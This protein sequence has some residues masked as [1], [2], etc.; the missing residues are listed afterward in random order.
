[1]HLVTP[2]T[3]ATPHSG[4]CRILRFWELKQLYNHPFS[5]MHTDRLERAGRFP[6]RVRLGANSVGWVEP[7]YVAWQAERIAARDSAPPEA[8]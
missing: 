7:E 1:M 5:R 6:K 2:P 8:A 4:G 3:Q